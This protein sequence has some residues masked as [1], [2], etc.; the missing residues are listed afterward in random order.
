[1]VTRIITKNDLKEAQ[2]KLK[3]MV[4]LIENTYRPEFI[5]SNIHLVLH[6]V[7]CCRDYGSIYSF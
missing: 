3:D 6:I 7:D 1:L 4:H 5:I 2:E